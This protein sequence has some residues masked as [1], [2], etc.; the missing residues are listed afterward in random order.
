MAIGF[1]TYYGNGNGIS[2]GVGT[3]IGVPAYALTDWAEIML[4]T[5]ELELIGL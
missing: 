5:D 3:A 2:K 1:L 4:I